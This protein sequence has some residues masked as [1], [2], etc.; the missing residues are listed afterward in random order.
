MLFLIDGGAFVYLSW[1]KTLPMTSP[2]SQGEKWFLSG[3]QNEIC[4][5]GAYR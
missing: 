1:L 4:E 5:L 2:L 3:L